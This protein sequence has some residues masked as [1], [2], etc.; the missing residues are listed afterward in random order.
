MEK[1]Q[2]LGDQGLLIT[3]G[4][5]ID[6]EI[7]KK[8]RRLY[9]AI[10]KERF[11]WLLDVVPAYT[12][13][14]INYNA[15]QIS[16][17]EACEMIKELKT[18]PR[19]KDLKLRRRKVI[20]TFYG[21]EMGPDLEELAKLKNKSIDEVIEIHSRPEY[22]VYMLGFTPGFPYLGG[23]DEEI[24]APR[25]KNP[26]KK[27]PKGSVGIAGSQTGI[28]PM[29]SPGGWRLI[30]R[31]PIPLF[32]PEREDPFYIKPGDILV[33]KSIDEKTFD[34]LEKESRWYHEGD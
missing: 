7:H 5:R 19:G 9:E 34:Q 4:N 30:G 32:D 27:I 22:L 24:A 2:P 29:E 21:G 6:P 28:Y 10:K 13:I 3:F 12:T 14:M 31:T 16:Y 11:S 33:F 17:E 20:P 18:H 26:R 15:L 23:M 1:I 8:V 25:L